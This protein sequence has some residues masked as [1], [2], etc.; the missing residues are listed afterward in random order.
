MFPVCHI[1]TCIVYI[2]VD[3]LNWNLPN[4]FSTDQ[5]LNQN[6]V[7]YIFFTVDSKDNW[8]IWTI[9]SKTTIYCQHYPHG[10]SCKNTS[11]LTEIIFLKSKL[12]SIWSW[13]FSR[14]H[15]DDHV[16]TLFIQTVDHCR[17][18]GNANSRCYYK[19][20]LLVIVLAHSS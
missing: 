6:I 3:I 12:L 15:I 16:F 10:D 5:K 9:W 7:C 4:Q 13:S 18:N 14:F 20:K 17:N 8:K 2:V 1:S 11:F 19:G